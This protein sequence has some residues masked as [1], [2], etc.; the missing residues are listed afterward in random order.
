MGGESRQ[1]D[2][3]ALDARAFLFG[4]R[5]ERVSSVDE[6]CLIA[7]IRRAR[8]L[9]VGRAEECG[10]K[11]NLHCHVAACRGG[12]ARVAEVNRHIHRAAFRRRDWHGTTDEELWRTGDRHWNCAVDFYS[13]GRL[14]Q[15]VTQSMIRSRR[16]QCGSRSLESVY[17]WRDT[18][19]SRI[20]NRLV[21][22]CVDGEVDGHLARFARV[23]S[24]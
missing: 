8:H 12:V 19:F 3:D 14:W 21:Q 10:F 5:R 13:T 17:E 23:E 20:R 9:H 24:A 6:I 22:R 15:R 1:I 18:H 16:A 2:D 7:R 11:R 4:A